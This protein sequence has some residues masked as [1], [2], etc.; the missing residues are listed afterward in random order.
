MG[1]ENTAS[2]P[3][4]RSQILVQLDCMG[5][6]IDDMIGAIADDA[7]REVFIALLR[8]AMNC[9]IKVY[10]LLNPLEMLEID[11]ANIIEFGVGHFL[12]LAEEPNDDTLTW[13]LHKVDD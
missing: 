11:R 7:E 4:L 5:S 1:Q 10:D 12:V 3:D 6:A 13:T 9:G 8:E 2:N